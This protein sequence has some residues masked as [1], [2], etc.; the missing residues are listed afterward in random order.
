MEHG[1]LVEAG[2][3]EQLLDQNGIYASLWIV[4][5]GLK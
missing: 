4:Q 5:S 3:H 2:T 1:K